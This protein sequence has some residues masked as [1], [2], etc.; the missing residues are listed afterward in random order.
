L[1]ELMARVADDVVRQEAAPADLTPWAASSDM[2]VVQLT[3]QGP[4]SSVYGTHR[5]LT[6]IV[7]LDLDR[8][9]RA[10]ADAYARFRDAYQRNWRQ[11]FDPI[12]LRLIVRR[13]KLAADLSIMPLIQFTDYRPL[14]RLSQGSAIPND[15]N[16]SPASLFHVALAVNRDSQEVREAENLL[17]GVHRFDVARPLAWLGDTVGLYFEDDPFFEEWAQAPDREKFF[18]RN[19][20]RL[21]IAAFAD[22]RDPVLCAAFMGGVKA[23]IEQLA[24]N[25]TTWETL[26]HNDQGYVHIRPQWTAPDLSDKFAIYYATT[27]ERLLITPS[28]SVLKRFLERRQQLQKRERQGDEGLSRGSSLPGKHLT[29]RANQ[30]ALEALAAVMG[31]DYQWAMQRQSWGNVPILNEWKRRYPDKDPTAVHETLYNARLVCP[32]G[33]QYIWND[34]WQTMEST[35]YGHPGK[36]KP[37]P[38][39]PPEWRRVVEAD[40]GLTFEN[41]G[42]RA[43]VEMQRKP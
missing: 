20:H 7:E 29:A 27:P 35:A 34:D 26:R 9:T 21:P 12:A 31:E 13:E 4:I 6:P 3:R 17:Q 36:P 42:L 1:T 41:N 24:P 25:L 33:G 18:N 32:G 43:R 2:G 28:E 40:F 39:V 14:M 19:N 37:G 5:F 23:A 10:E 15:G 8:A 11:F 30:R 16:R 22:V 38:G